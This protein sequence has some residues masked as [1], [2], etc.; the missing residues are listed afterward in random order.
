MSATR[1]GSGSAHQT[2]GEVCVSNRACTK[3]KICGATAMVALHVGGVG[4]SDAGLSSRPTIR[5]WRRA[6]LRPIR[7]AR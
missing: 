2:N 5:L 1:T 7:V 6:M 3:H 4:E